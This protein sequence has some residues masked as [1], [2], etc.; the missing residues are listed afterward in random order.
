MVLFTHNVKEIKGA[1]HKNGDGYFDVTCKRG[2]RV[3]STCIPIEMKIPSH[4]VSC[5]FAI[6][7]HTIC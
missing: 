6:D 4:M 3:F 5:T 7:V 1:A 2:L